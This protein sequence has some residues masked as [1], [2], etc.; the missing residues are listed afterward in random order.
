VPHDE[1]HKQLAPARIVGLFSILT[2]AKL[3][4]VAGFI[5]VVSVRGNGKLVVLC[6]Q[7]QTGRNLLHLLDG[8]S[9]QSG[10]RT[11]VQQR[12]GENNAKANPQSKMYL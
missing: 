4:V 2:K 6:H 1:Y 5:A 10:E 8:Y 12:E 9:L 3:P 7:N 11:L